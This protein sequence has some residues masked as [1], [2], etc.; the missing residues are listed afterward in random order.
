RE[1]PKARQEQDGKERAN[2]ARQ[3]GGSTTSIGCVSRLR[4]DAG[5]L[6]HCTDLRPNS[7]NAL[8]LSGP[9]ATS[10]RL[11]AHNASEADVIRARI[12]RVIHARSGPIS[13]AVVFRAS[14][15]SAL[16]DL[17]RCWSA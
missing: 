3:D 13:P 12:D 1:Q 4:T 5:S 17:A 9:C 7:N 10:H 14:E 2:C 15:R 6:E 8:I 16:Q 11:W